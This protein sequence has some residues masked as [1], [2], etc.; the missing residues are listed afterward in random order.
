MELKIN[1]GYKELLE[2]IKQLPAEQIKKLKKDLNLD[3]IPSKPGASKFRDFL[4]Q[5]P[6][7]DDEQYH[8]FEANRQ[9]FNAW[10]NH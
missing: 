2:L 9:F 7:M 4:L 3:P 6:I 10:R 8:Q 1:I 5:G